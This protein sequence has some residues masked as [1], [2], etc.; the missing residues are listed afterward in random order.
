LIAKAE[1][2]MGISRKDALKRL[3]ALVPKVEEHLAKIS[4]NPNGRDVPHWIKEIK[5]W[6]SQ[7]EAMLPHVG[8]RTSA[9]WQASIDGWKAKVQD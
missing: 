2:L 5:G 8:D 1:L 4:R 9:E 6:I 7:M 3:L